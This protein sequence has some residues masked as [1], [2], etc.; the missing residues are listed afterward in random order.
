MKLISTFIVIVLLSGCQS[1][2]Q[3]V[4][5][6]QNSISIA[7]Q[8]YAISSK[9]SLSDESI[10]NLRTF[11]Q[12]N[13]SLAEMELKK[14]KSLDEIARWYCPS[15]NTIASLLTPLE[16]NDYMFYQK[17]NGPQLPYISDL[18]T[19]VKYRQELNLSHV[20]IEQLLHHSEEIEKRFGVQDYKHDS[21][22]KQYLAEILSE[23]QY[24]AFFII[25]KTRQAEK[26]AAQQWKQIQVHQLCSTTCDSLAIIKQLYEFEREKSGI[27]EYMSS[28]GDN[29]GYDKERDR[30][31]AHKPLLLLKLETIESFSHN[32][33][34]DIICKRE[35]TKLSEGKCLINVV[36]HQQLEDYFKF[37]SQKR[38][39]EQAQRYWDELKNYDFIRKKDSVQVVSELADYELRLAVAEQWIS[40]DNSRKHL[41]A[42]EDVVNGKP[43]ILK[44]KEEWDKKEKERKMVRF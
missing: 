38:A 9:I 16:G 14:G 17:N 40:L 5:I 13:D 15:I 41:F 1:K 33:L 32:K 34:L 22:E 28:R 37:V 29:K 35:V 4:V 3:S 25:R 27:L 19:V 36:T 24:K 11:F 8:I 18:R 39:D 12:E 43:E 26:I 7:M 6:S 2:E 10:M 30:L 42:R 31:N 44:K 20:Q 21:M 23:T